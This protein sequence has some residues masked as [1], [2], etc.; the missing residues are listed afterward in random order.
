MKVGLTGGIGSG[1]S[2][3]ARI[4]AELGAFVIDTDELAREVV[5]PGTEGLREIERLWP[6]VIRNGELDRAALAAIVFNDTPAREQLNAILH[7]RIRQL[8]DERARAARP[9]QIVLHVIPLLF[10][11]GLDKAMD[12]NIVVVAPDSERIVRVTARDAAAEADVR[13]RIAAQIDPGE[14]R[15]QADFVIENDGDLQH[16]R[17]H[18]ARV[19]EQLLTSA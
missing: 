14:A 1:K 18:A 17:S 8:A 13:A 2:E 11:V 7:P 5:E 4:F 16:L 3:F 6:Q 10:E 9:G 12:A 19:Y 15:R